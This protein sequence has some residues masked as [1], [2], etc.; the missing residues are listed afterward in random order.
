MA[1]NQ[2]DV[3][4]KV[5]VTPATIS[6]IINNNRKPSIEL[7]ERLAELFPGTTAWE[8]MKNPSDTWNRIRSGAN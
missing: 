3:A 4:K 7:A 1:L 5:N 8:W 6:R 2:S